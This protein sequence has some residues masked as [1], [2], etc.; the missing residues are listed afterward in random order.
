MITKDILQIFVIANV[1]L[2]G[3]CVYVIAPDHQPS[4]PA[5]A[6]IAR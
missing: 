3:I 5:V 4:H 6:V 1:A 2:I